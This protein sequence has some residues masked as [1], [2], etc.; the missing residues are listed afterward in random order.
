MNLLSNDIDFFKKFYKLGH[1]RDFRLVP[2]GAWQA[3]LTRARRG[4]YG[5]KKKSPL[6]NEAGSSYG[7][8]VVGRVRG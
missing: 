1:G 8:R 7:W 4:G 5:G 6:V 2:K 3:G